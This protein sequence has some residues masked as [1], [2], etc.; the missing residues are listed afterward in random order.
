[1]SGISRLYFGYSDLFVEE[2]RFKKKHTKVFVLIV[3]YT[4]EEKFL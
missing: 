2:E 1:M 4:S 3:C